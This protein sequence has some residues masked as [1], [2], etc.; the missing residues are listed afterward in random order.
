MYP[1]APEYF[2]QLVTLVA[3]VVF[4]GYALVFRSNYRR[5]QPPT[6]TP[7]VIGETNDASTPS[8]TAGPLSSPQV[9]SSPKPPASSQSR[10]KINVDTKIDD[11][12]PASD[13]IVYPGAVAT[14][15]NSYET[16]ADGDSVYNWYKEELTKR[17]YQIRNNV[18][19]KANEKFK[20]VLQGVSGNVSIKVTIDQ[21]SSDA[22]T[23]IL[24]E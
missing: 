3:V 12:T 15:G 20:A 2:M 9:S 4:I 22:K 19:T 10:I 5:T 23:K 24:L 8:P 18:R 6:A 17:S 1:S 13:K 7:E 21:E 16:D 14:G 11:T